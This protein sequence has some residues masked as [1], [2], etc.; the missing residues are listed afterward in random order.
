MEG[1]KQELD[2]AVKDLQAQI[3][4]EEIRANKMASEA[5]ELQERLADMESNL[6]AEESKVQRLQME[7]LT[8]EAQMNRLSEETSSQNETLTKVITHILYCMLFDVS[9]YLNDV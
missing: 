9:V 5:S 6:G 4:D 3:E 1:K 7:K 8:L 2:S